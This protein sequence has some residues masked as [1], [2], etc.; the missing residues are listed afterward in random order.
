M[1]VMVRYTVKPSEH[2]GN[3]ERVRAVFA[4]LAEVRPPDFQYSCFTLEDGVSF[5]HVASQEGDES[6][7]GRIEAFGRFQEDIR[8]RCDEPPVVTQL[9]E[10]GS[11][12]F[13]GSAA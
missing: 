5:V 13:D 9:D 7:L 8:E 3:L 12:R 2:E 10:V 11:F 1:S 4:E 6:P